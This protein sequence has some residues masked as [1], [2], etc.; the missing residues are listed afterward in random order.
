MK[1]FN[2]STAVSMFQIIAKLTSRSKF[3]DFKA[4]KAEEGKGR[5]KK[6]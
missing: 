3:S 4:S 1:L 2:K 5:E 6:M